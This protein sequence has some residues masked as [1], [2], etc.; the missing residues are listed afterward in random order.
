[1]TSENELDS[2]KLS[3]EPLIVDIGAA[4]WEIW[5]NFER[6]INGFLKKLKA[7]SERF[8]D[9]HLRFLLCCLLYSEIL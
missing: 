7:D 4:L 9:F 3:V 1:M 2:K 6:V 5:P 8:C